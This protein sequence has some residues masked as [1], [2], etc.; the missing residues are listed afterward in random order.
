MNQGKGPTCHHCAHCRGA[1]ISEISGCT[2][3]DCEAYGRWVPLRLMRDCISAV[4]AD[5]DKDDE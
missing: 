5:H 1:S 4:R 2:H 3:I